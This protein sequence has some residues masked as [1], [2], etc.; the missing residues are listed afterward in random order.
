MTN[1]IYNHTNPKYTIEHMEMWTITCHETG[2]DYEKTS[3]S[4]EEHVKNLKLL[5]QHLHY[6]HKITVN[7]IML[8][9]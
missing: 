8:K 5:A 6:I 9:D 1:N 4:I 7:P 3:Y 2:C